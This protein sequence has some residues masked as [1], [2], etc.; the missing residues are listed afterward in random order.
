MEGFSQDSGG[1]LPRT[2]WRKYPLAACH[3]LFDAEGDRLPAAVRDGLT[4]LL[5]ASGYKTAGTKTLAAIVERLE[6]SLRSEPAGVAG[7]Q[8]ASPLAAVYPSFALSRLRHRPQGDTRLYLQALPNAILSQVETAL[9]AERQ[10]W[11][12]ALY[13]LG[14]SA[15][16]HLRRQLVLRAI[17]QAYRQQQWEHWGLPLPDGTRTTCR[18]RNRMC[19]A[20]QDWL[21]Q[22][23]VDGR[24]LYDLA[25]ELTRRIVSR[26][27]SR[28]A[29]PHAAQTWNEEMRAL[30]HDHHN[31]AL[32]YSRIAADNGDEEIWKQA[33]GHWAV[34]LGN[35]AYW[36]EWL[37]QRSPFYGSTAD[38]SP[39][40]TSKPRCLS[41]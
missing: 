41:R 8:E 16:S 23:I 7:Q 6:T 29:V 30:Y 10:E 1:L 12:A 35:A 15:P 38:H 26:A 36:E 31:A 33:I 40:P 3:A 18:K 24:D 32:V 37:P 11:Q 21:L 39:P 17:E 22:K 27:D 14:P 2:G 13:S 28:D 34:V 4:W 19:V 9:H 20:A 25:E 5:H